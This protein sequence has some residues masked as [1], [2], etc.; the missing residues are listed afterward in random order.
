MELAR[1]LRELGRHRRLLALGVLVAVLAAIL[2]VYRIE[3]GTLKPRSLKYSAAS[4]QVLVDSATSLLG[5]TAP[6]SE[7]LAVRA[8]VFANFMT[9][10]VLLELIGRK[11]GLSGAQ[12]YAAG[13]INTNQL[14]SEK[15]PT[16]LRRNIE[17]TGETKPYRLD[18]E[19]QPTIPTITISTQAPT[20][21]MAVALANAAATS[22]HRYVANLQS[23]EGIARASRLAIRQLGLA[24]GAVV[25]GGVSKEL[26][27]LAFIAV[28]GVW[29]GGLLSATRFRETWRASK[30][31]KTH[32]EDGLAE[33]ADQ[34]EH[35]ASVTL[36]A[37][38]RSG[39]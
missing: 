30:L 20:T 17:I 23:T 25:N 13:P 36:T 21:S 15:E 14:R 7:P 26:A 5:S 27:L 12:L 31:L 37:A 3:G 35:A 24:T 18:F 10:P 11:V 1:A 16:D 9:S 8:Q 28:L 29:C 6:Q 34:E 38:A 2:S 4:T 32:G 22:L 33:T 39:L 19:A